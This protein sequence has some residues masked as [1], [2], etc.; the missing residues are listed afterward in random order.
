[1]TRALNAFDDEF[2]ARPSVSGNGGPIIPLRLVMRL[3]EP[4][5]QFL[6]GIDGI[7]SLG[8]GIRYGLR[9]ITLSSASSLNSTT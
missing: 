6:D 2:E 1:V 5:D 9:S 8:I 4:G 7:Q 3:L